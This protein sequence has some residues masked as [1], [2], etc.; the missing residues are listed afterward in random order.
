[1][2][3]L[4]LHKKEIFNIPVYEKTGQYRNIKTVDRYTFMENVYS[5]GEYVSQK[6]LG[7]FSYLTD[8]DVP[9][10]SGRH[11]GTTD[12]L[13]ALI[14]FCVLLYRVLSTYD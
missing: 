12:V 2:S 1:M 3:R 7:K 11:N 9:L 6:I 10:Q 14:S 8:S 5:C 13:Q 4:E